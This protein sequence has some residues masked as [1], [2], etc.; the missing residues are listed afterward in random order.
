LV[1]RETGKTLKE[2]RAELIAP[3]QVY[4]F[5]VREHGVCG[6]TSGAQQYGE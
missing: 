4:D 2:K 3:H 5:L 6:R 1:F